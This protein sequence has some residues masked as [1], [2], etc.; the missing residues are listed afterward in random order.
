MR[1]PVGV[2][3]GATGGIGE[4]TARRLAAGGWRLVLGARDP[5]RLE[6]LAQSLGATAVVVEARDP[7]Q[8][9]AVVSRAVE[10]HGRLDGLVNCFGTLLLKPAH[11]TSDA[12]WQE[13]LEVNLG[14]AFAAVRAGTRAMT[15]EGGSIVLRSSAAARI[16]LANHEAIAA[17]KGGVQ[18][19]ALS[20]AASYAHR[21]IRVNAV[22][23]GLVR[24]RL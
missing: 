24:T 11:L 18:A 7:A 13:T 19:L 3:L 23:P 14:S 8:V 4:E 15:K 17:A 2:V 5:A 22:A 20:A 16:G 1:S 9:E 12:E 21:R 10:L 6:P